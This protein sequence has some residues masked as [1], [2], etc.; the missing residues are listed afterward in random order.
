MVRLSPK[1]EC[2]VAA[3]ATMR[4]KCN[5]RSSALAKRLNPTKEFGTFHEISIGHFC[6]FTQTRKVLSGSFP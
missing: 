4:L 5:L 2:S 3:F 1:I 6:P